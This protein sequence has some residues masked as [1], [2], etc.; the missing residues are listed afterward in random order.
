MHVHWSS[1]CLHFS[2]FHIIVCGVHLSQ[3]LVLL[4]CHAGCAAA[5]ETE[6]MA[7]TGGAGVDSG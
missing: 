4:D 6:P 1:E 7:A 3:S 2:A 5:R